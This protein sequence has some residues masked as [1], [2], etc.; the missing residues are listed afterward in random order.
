MYFQSRPTMWEFEEKTMGVKV[1]TDLSTQIEE[2]ARQKRRKAAFPEALY[3]AV[4]R[5]GT[6][7][8]TSTVIANA[9]DSEAHALLQSCAQLSSI[10]K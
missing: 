3:T 4:L 8:E 1:K 6:P 5:S 2:A 10:N 9:K 7:V